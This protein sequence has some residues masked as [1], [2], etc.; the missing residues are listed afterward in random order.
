MN[1]VVIIVLCLLL[2][3]LFI[4]LVKYLFEKLIIGIFHVIYIAIQFVFYLLVGLI[5]RILLLIFWFKRTSSKYP[6]AYKKYCNCYNFSSEF[7][8]DDLKYL[9]YY[10]LKTKSFWKR[11]EDAIKN[12]NELKQEY[13]RIRN[14]YPIGV[15]YFERFEKYYGTKLEEIIVEKKNEIFEY[16]AVYSRY[17]ELKN[18]YPNGLKK[19]E[20][21][22]S[23]KKSTT[24]FIR[25]K[26]IINNEIQIKNFEDKLK[27]Q[28]DVDVVITPSQLKTIN[29]SSK[30]I[31]SSFPKSNSFTLSTHYPSDYDKLKKDFLKPKDDYYEYIQLL[32]DNGINYLYHFTDRRNLSSIKNYGGL[33]SWKYC[34]N[35]NINIPC[36]GGDSFFRSLDE[37]FNLGNYVRLSFFVMTIQCLGD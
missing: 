26:D 33:Y 9:N 31:V 22:I 16:Q 29:V 4:Y 18:K 32:V 24:P 20:D 30:P 13:Q 10:L 5:S 25:L 36:P 28:K 19:Y 11:E 8:W 6:N 7:D 2:N 34:V 37:S 12:R 3:L 17:L 15:S 21:I 23:N 35:H 1:D 27:I 14:L